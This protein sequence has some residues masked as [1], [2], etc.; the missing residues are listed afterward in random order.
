MVRTVST[1]LVVGLVLMSPPLAAQGHEHQH[2]DAQSLAD[3]SA[4]PL[5]QNLGRLHRT[6]RTRSILA[7]RYFDQGLRLTYAFNHAE[8]VR[9]FSYATELDSSC[10]MCWWGIANALGPNI[11]L[12]MEPGVNT[13]AWNASQVALSLAAG[14]GPRDRA[15]IEAQATRYV[16][17]STVDRAVLDSAYV[18]K[19]RIVF[20]RFP[21]DLDVRALFAE[22]MLDLRPWDQWGKD[23]TPQPGTREV[24][25]VL[26]AG[27]ARSLEHP[28]LC[29][30]YIHA[31]EASPTPEKAMPCAQRLPRLMP[32]A[33]HL[34]HMPA[35]I[36]MRMGDYLQ[37]VRHNQHAVHSDDTYLEG[38]H[39]ES[40][41]GLVYYTHNWHFL[42]VAAAMAGMEATA[43]EAARKTA[44][45]FPLDLARKY[46][47]L[48]FWLP[49]P[50]FALL[51]F[52]RWE[53][54]LAEPAPP[55]DLRYATAMWHFA[56][57]MAQAMTGQ[58][59][60]AEADADSVAEVRGTAPAMEAAGLPEAALLLGLAEETLRGT[61]AARI[62]DEEE[63]V[64]HLQA[65][66]NLEDQLGY[67]EPNPWYVP[68]RQ[69]LGHELLRLGK[70][71]EAETAYREDLRN[72]KDNGWSLLGLSLALKAQ[73]KN[74]AA[75]S[76]DRR[77]ERA[78]R[79]AD[80]LVREARF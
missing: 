9:A 67:E 40:I 32:G 23:G 8:A 64:R 53:E 42:S 56:R 27:L 69:V 72:N 34:V 14:A 25:A 15:L 73:D 4:P 71:Q 38:S 66:V 52:E 2:S 31:I 80:I 20:H 5:Y 12:P 45:A 61:L 68:A 1:A 77:R 6:I 63:A 17:D 79:E 7:Q 75:A 74:A 33:G 11:N 41:Y 28:G 24:V 51:R 50:Y 76:V 58:S 48:E 78:W 46:P 30:Y 36:A 3:S 16:A 54:I 39:A 59:D 13:T 47:H 55:A 35:H 44:G 43:T 18:D 37:A 57:G 70:A 22:S 29:H 26:E 49:M 65:A 10:A 21:D 19:M 60:L 62:H